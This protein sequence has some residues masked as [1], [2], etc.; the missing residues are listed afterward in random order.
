M[1]KLEVFHFYGAQSRSYEEI[2]KF[3]QERVKDIVSGQAAESLIF[4]EHEAVITKG[5]RSQDSNIVDKTGLP[6]FDIERGGDVTLHS[7]GQLVIYLLIKLQGGEFL[8]GLS[9]FLRFCEQIIIDYLINKGLR[10]GRFG[11]TGVWIKDSGNQI[12]KIASLGI[13]VRRWVTYHGIS[14]NISNDLSLFDK[15]RPCDFDASIMTSMKNE[16]VKL[17]LKEV[18]EELES[19]FISRFG[20]Q[21]SDLPMDLGI[22][23][24]SARNHL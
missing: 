4:C 9:S 5:R 24:T 19:I 3:Q 2:W 20:S 21:K 1:M 13:A 15:I 8:G 12:K 22:M 14:L 16:S 17:S 23:E 6:V 11:P 10:A 7:P 18:A